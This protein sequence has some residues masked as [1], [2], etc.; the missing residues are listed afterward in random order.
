MTKTEYRKEMFIWAYSS[1]RLSPSLGRSMEQAHIF[2][3]KREE[4]TTSAGSLL[5]LKYPRDGLP[6]T[7]EHQLSLPKLFQQQEPRVQIPGPMGDI[8]HTNHQSQ[9]QMPTMQK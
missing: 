9:P 8:S 2:K 3:F 4:E 5:I 1:R 7:R 6:S